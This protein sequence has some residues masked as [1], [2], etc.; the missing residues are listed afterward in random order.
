MDIRCLAG[1]RFAA[2]GAGTGRAVEK[3]RD[4]CGSDP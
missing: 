3:K 2:I 1:L 4:T